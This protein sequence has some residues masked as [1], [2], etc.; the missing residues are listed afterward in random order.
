M[1]NRSYRSC[2]TMSSVSTLSASM[3][4][5]SSE[6]GSEKETLLL[7]RSFCGVSFFLSKYE[8]HVLAAFSS[9]FSC[10]C[11]TNL[12]AF[13]LIFGFSLMPGK[14]LL[15]CNFPTFSKMSSNVSQN[16]SCSISP[17][18]SSTSPSPTKSEL[19]DIGGRAVELENTLLFAAII[20]CRATPEM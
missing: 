11:K 8:R 13:L 5:T 2:F 3:S 19:V 4:K 10:D 14:G 18:S 15:W 1:L 12:D 6:E 7:K 20:Y 9:I 16:S 17:S